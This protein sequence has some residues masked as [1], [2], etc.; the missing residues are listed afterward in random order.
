MHC[1]PPTSPPIPPAHTA[2]CGHE[3]ASPSREASGTPWKGNF[4]YSAMASNDRIIHRFY[5]RSA[6][7]CQTG[8][9]NHHHPRCTSRVEFRTAQTYMAARQRGPHLVR[10]RLTI[11]CMSQVDSGLV[12]SG[13]SQIMHGPRIRQVLPILCTYS[14][15]LGLALQ[16][17]FK[18]LRRWSQSGQTGI[19][20]HT[21]ASVLTT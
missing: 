11:T 2:C 1:Q 12:V 13:H 3:G 20:S 17:F 19:C 8:R 14:L 4:I 7:F 9:S 5:L 6:Y 15:G 21:S 10:I 18:C 16:Y